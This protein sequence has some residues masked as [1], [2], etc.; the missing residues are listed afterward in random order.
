MSPASLMTSQAQLS[1][2]WSPRPWP[3]G[4]LGRSLL[5]PAPPTRGLALSAGTGSLT[6]LI[7]GLWGGQSP[8]EGLSENFLAERERGLSDEFSE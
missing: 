1:D 8:Q 7:R 2:C 5:S 6:L 4:L 3:T